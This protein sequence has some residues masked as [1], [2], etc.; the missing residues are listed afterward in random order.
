[1]TTQTQRQIQKQGHEVSSLR[2]ETSAAAQTP[3]PRFD[4][5]VAAQLW[6]EFSQYP[7][8]A[9]IAGRRF[10][11]LAPKIPDSEVLLYAIAEAAFEGHHA[12]GALNEPFL[13][14]RCARIMEVVWAAQKADDAG[15]ELVSKVDRGLRGISEILS[16][17]T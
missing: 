5:R 8:E 17:A 7:R 4:G 6:A 15:A 12:A 1:M 16:G 2:S 14:S 3:T 13:R 10:A 9:G 11:T